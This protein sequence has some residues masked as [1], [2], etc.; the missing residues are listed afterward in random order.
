[1]RSPLLRPAYRTRIAGLVAEDSNDQFPLVLAQDG[2][3][4]KSIVRAASSEASEPPYGSKV[5]VCLEDTNEL[6]FHIPI[7][8][9][10]LAN[11][12]LQRCAATM[13]QG[14]VARLQCSAEWSSPLAAKA[15]GSVV[16][17]Y[18]VELLGW[19]DAP[20]DEEIEKANTEAELA[21]LE[22]YRREA[23]AAS[24]STM[25][26]AERRKA[27]RMAAKQAK[28]KSFGSGFGAK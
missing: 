24:R 21:A 7:V 4:R 1:M 23:E 22:R 6:E 16:A 14:E 27:E 9:P 11:D 13:K 28:K 17:S 3:V 12:A 25:S 18:Q 15:L 2:G 26:R 8:N 5:K 19:S 10:G 20:S